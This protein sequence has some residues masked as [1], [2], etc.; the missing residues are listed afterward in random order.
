M[1]RR[2]MQVG[3]VAAALA[4]AGAARA[5]DLGNDEVTLKNGGSV[6]GTVVSLEPGTS[7]KIIEYGE[8]TPRV[9]PWGQ[10]ADVEKGK[11]APKTVAQPGPAGPGYGT[12]PPPSQPVAPPEPKLG[13]RG[14]VRLHV[15]S[16][17]PARILAH[18][19]PTVGH[20]GGYV[21]V[22]DRAQGVCMSPCDKVL[23]GSAGQTFSV[24]GEFPTPEPFTLAPHS[25]DM[26]LKLK[27]GSNGMRAGGAWAVVF[28]SLGVIG[29]AITLPI[30]YAVRSH[31]SPALRLAGIG[32]LAAGLP[33]LGGGIALLI[34]GKSSYSLQPSV[35][36]TGAIQPRY[37]MG[38]F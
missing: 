13:S 32:Q 17:V 16:P 3:L 25:G 9:I 28:G 36:R 33:L 20:V 31:A 38:E 4:F 12:P 10:V 34:L 35:S 23:D 1:S 6:R 22:M 30:A 24:H 5:D 29:G 26:T 11:F 8:K 27:P 14:V 2:W 37:W 7:V 18:E 21:F 19:A 15:E